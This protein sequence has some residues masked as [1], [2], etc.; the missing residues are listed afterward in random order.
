MVS[1]A[2]IAYPQLTPERE[3]ARQPTLALMEAKVALIME[4]SRQAGCDV[5]VLSAFGCGAFGNP[6][7]VVAELFR[8]ALERS[9]LQRVT[10]CVVDDHNARNSHN[11]RGNFLPFSEAFSGREVSQG[12]RHARSSTFCTCE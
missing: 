4:A 10:F 3:Y 7:E 11:P 8:R 5:A 9:Q 1:C 2:A 12:S 6:P